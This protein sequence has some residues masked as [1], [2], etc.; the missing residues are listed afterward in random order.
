MLQVC[1][2]QAIKYTVLKRLLGHV[3]TDELLDAIDH[4]LSVG[5]ITRKRIGYTTH[6]TVTVNL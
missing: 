1:R 5:A 3:Y 4:L 2:R 6:Y